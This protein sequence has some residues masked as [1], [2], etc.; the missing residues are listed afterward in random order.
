MLKGLAR[1]IR[2]AIAIDPLTSGSIPTT[3]GIYNLF[4]IMALFEI[5]T[6]KR[7][8]DDNNEHILIYRDKISYTA[9]ICPP[10]WFLLNKN[11]F[12][13]PFYIATIFLLYAI[14]IYFGSTI[15]IFG[16][17]FIHLF[18]GFQSNLIREWLLNLRDYKLEM[19]VTSEESN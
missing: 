12:L 8:F 13:V 11:F 10:L 6:K 18:F 16:I 1:C 7:G 3:K 2:E 15:M 4:F 9:L 5:Y 19:I 17:I 14:S